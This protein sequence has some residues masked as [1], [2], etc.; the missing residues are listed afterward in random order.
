MQV[1]YFIYPA[2]VDD[3]LFSFFSFFFFF[4]SRWWGLKRG[5]YPALQPSPAPPNLF[6][7]EHKRDK[8][9][10]HVRS[11]SK[12]N[13]IKMLFLKASQLLSE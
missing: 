9:L 8:V 10:V 12:S 4:F 11:T 2:E 5:F 7:T 1:R 13:L 6:I 3:F